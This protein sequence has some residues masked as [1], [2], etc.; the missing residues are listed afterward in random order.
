MLSWPRTKDPDEVLDYYFDWSD[1]L[2]PPVQGSTVSP[3]TITS[4]TAIVDAGSVAITSQNLQGAMLQLFIAG[5]TDKDVAC[6]RSTLVTSRGRT[7]E[8][9]SRLKV[10]YR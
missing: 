4:C 9:T 10:R 8:V 2:E 6:I 5:G 7:L 3:E 1:A